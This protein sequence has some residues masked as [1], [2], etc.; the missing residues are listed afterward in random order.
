MGL[1]KIAFWGLFFFLTTSCGLV[2]NLDTIGQNL[3]LTEEPVIEPTN[4]FYLAI[5]GVAP[6]RAELVIYD[7]AGIPRSF[8]NNTLEFRADP[9]IV[10]FQ[11]RSGFSSFREGSGA[12]LV[13]LEVGIATIYYSIDGTEQTE[14]FKIIIP[15]QSL[16]QI[17]MGEARS[18]LLDE[19]TVE[20]GAVTLDSRSPTGEAVAHVVKNRIALIEENSWPGLFKANEFDY[21]LKPPQSW[22]D[23]VIKAPDQFNP[24]DESDPSHDAYK[25]GASRDEVSD[26]LLAAY[27]QAVITAAI[28]FSG[29]SSDLTNGAFSFRSPNENQWRDIQEAL[30]TG[31]TTL[32]NGIGVSDLIF[33]AFSPVQV[34][35]HPN[36]QTYDNGRPTF[37]FTRGPRNTS[38]AAVTDQP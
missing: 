5:G 1:R 33:P 2:Q 4:T 23:A 6:G 26:N 27:D 3:T 18:E 37:I 29:D 22:Y 28:V 10:A 36:V 24:T 32:P 30:K 8:L 35:V 16:I 9:E 17:L 15:P 14:T 13:P 34:L 21:D 12:T 11:P 31:A 25:N 19:V 20:D 7:E 38:E